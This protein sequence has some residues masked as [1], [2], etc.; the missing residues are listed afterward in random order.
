MQR[1]GVCPLLERGKT[2]VLWPTRPQLESAEAIASGA[3][4]GTT[5]RNTGNTRWFFCWLDCKEYYMSTSFRLNEQ[6]RQWIEQIQQNLGAVGT[7]GAIDYALM[8]LSSG[9]TRVEKRYK[10]VMLDLDN[11][12]TPYRESS[13]SEFK[14]ELLPGVQERCKELRSKGVLLGIITNQ[15]YPRPDLH[16]FLDWVR[17]KTGV[18]CIEVGTM[19]DMKPNPLMLRRMMDGLGLYPSE[20]LMVGDDLNDEIAALRAG[21]DFAWA[22]EYMKKKVRFEVRV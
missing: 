21:V 2:Q 6:R 14:R 9:L 4:N 18:Q 19:E 7:S 22:R 1:W 11:T 16:E 13:A 5:R 3:S 20:C 8:A 17:D 12:L 15:R 10:L